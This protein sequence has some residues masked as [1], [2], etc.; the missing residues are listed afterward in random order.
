MP[1][2]GRQTIGLGRKL[3]LRSSARRWLALQVETDDLDV[4]L[5][6]LVTGGVP[7]LVALPGVGVD[8]AGRLLFTAGGNPRPALRGRVRPTLR[9]RP[10]PGQLRTH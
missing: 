8:T 1:T 6:A 3:V 2:S 4:H 5:T 9:R 7:D 10:D